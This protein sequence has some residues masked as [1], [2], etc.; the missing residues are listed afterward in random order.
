M[1]VYIVLPLYIQGLCTKCS[2][3]QPLFKPEQQIQEV[4]ATPGE[5]KEELTTVEVEIEEEADSG[6]SDAEDKIPEVVDESNSFP[7]GSVVWAR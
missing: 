4:V 2:E 7:P 1:C 3:L 6:E 5:E